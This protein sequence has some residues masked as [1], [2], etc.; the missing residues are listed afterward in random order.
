[1]SSLGDISLS[2]RDIILMS[3]CIGAGLVVL[4]L[5]GAWIFFCC[6]MY[7]DKQTQQK[8]RQRWRAATRR[9]RNVTRAFS[10]R[11]Q[12][13][14]RN[15]GRDRDGR[16]HPSRSNLGPESETT[17]VSSNEDINHEI[18]QQ[19]E[20]SKQQPNHRSLAAISNSNKIQQAQQHRRAPN[21]NNLYSSYQESDEE[22]I[23]NISML[24][25]ANIS[26]EPPAYASVSNLNKFESD[27]FYNAATAPPL[28]L[29]GAVLPSPIRIPKPAGR[30]ETHHTPYNPEYVQRR[31]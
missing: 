25:R 4:V 11:T 13:R 16:V 26:D 15:H 28:P 7:K 12:R 27:V 18:M 2:E 6:A 1:M 31:F 5:C 21:R 14:R 20:R 24:P 8:I 19:L 23:D 29:P 9:A 22:D 17:F 3:V 30:Q 10:R